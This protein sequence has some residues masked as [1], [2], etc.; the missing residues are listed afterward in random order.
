MGEK[1]YR[2]EVCGWEGVA[3]PLD[4][5]DAAPCPQCGV[6]LYPLSWKQTW[7]TAIL[8][9]GIALAVVAAVAYYINYLNPPA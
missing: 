9:I 5:G 2:C 1:S 7:G 4:A 8:W 6:F 3:E